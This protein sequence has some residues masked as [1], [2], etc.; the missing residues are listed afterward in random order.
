MVDQQTSEEPPFVVL[1]KSSNVLDKESLA[2]VLKD[3]RRLNLSIEDAINLSGQLPQDVLSTLKEANQMVISKQVRLETAVRALRL[4]V[5]EEISLAEAMKQ[6]N[7]VHTRTTTVYSLSNQLTGL[8]LDA[9]IVTQ[10]QL[11]RAVVTA[12]KTGMLTGRVLLLNQVVSVQLL[13]SCIR[14]CLSVQ[15]GT[16]SRVEVVDALKRVRVKSMSVEQALFE[17]GTYKQPS[18]YA[19]QLGDLLTMAGVVVVSD[20]LECWELVIVKHKRFNQIALEQ[21]LITN[22]KLEQA[23]YLQSLVAS[24]NMEPYQAAR[25]LRNAAKLG[26]SVYDAVGKERV[27][28]TDNGGTRVGDLLVGA[29]IATQTAIDNAISTASSNI[30]IGKL[31]LKA[32]VVGEETL[33]KALR[34]QSLFRYGYISRL[35]AVRALRQSHEKNQSIEETFNSMSLFMPS[36]MQWQ[37]V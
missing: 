10:A 27:K 9:G 17:L 32:N 23:T 37:W 5:H 6:L 7:E 15:E 34:L 31:L 36:S 24:K 19:L 14:G 18:T 30:K 28:P 2:T 25:V 29:E 22:E 20:L 11:A 3:A 8:M 21:G 13:F 33:F 16:Q 12:E 26:V 1:L 35:D 4:V